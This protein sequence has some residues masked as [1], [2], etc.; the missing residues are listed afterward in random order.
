MKTIRTK[1]LVMFMA[2]A[3]VFAMTPQIAQT[4]VADDG[5]F[6]VP[7]T[8]TSGFNIDGV[9]VPGGGNVNQ[10]DS[11]SYCYYADADRAGSLPPG[12]VIETTGGKIFKLAPYNGKNVVRLNNATGNVSVNFSDDSKVECKK[13]AFLATGGNGGGTVT[14][15]V[16]FSGQNSIVSQNFTVPDWDDTE[17][18]V[19]TCGRC[20]TWGSN[21]TEK[22]D[23]GLFECAINIPAEYQGYKVDSL[24]LEATCSSNDA[25]ICIFAVS[26]V[27]TSSKLTVLFDGNGG[28]ATQ[29]KMTADANASITLPDATWEGVHF[30]GWFDGDTKVGDAG[31]TYTVTKNVLLKAHWTDNREYI[32]Y[33][34]TSYSANKVK[35]YKNEDGTWTHPTRSNYVFKGFSTAY[36][37]AVI[38]DSQLESGG[39][40]YAIWEEAPYIYVQWPNDRSP[41]RYYL[42]ESGKVNLPKK[43][44]TVENYRVDGYYKDSSLKEEIDVT[45]AI[46]KALYGKTIFAGT[47]RTGTYIWVQGKRITSKNCSDVLG[48]GKV[49]FDMKTGVL[50]LNNV[51]I[52]SVVTE[53]YSEGIT[54]GESLKIKLIGKNTINCTSGDNIYNYQA[55]IFA[56]GKIKISGSGSLTINMAADVDTEKYGLKAYGT[57]DIR[58]DLNIN[59]KGDYDSAGYGLFAYDDVT[60]DGS[61]AKISV[62]NSS[63]SSAYG[64]FCYGEDLYVKND[65]DLK[66]DAKTGLYAIDDLLIHMGS[67]MEVTG[68]ERAFNSVYL[69][70]EARNQ[71]VGYKEIGDTEYKRWESSS[72]Y[73]LDYEDIKSV[74]IPMNKTNHIKAVPRTCTK[75]GNIEYWSMVADGETVYYNMAYPDSDY[76]ISLA[77]TVVK[78]LGGEHKWVLSKVIKKATAKAAGK[79]LNK[80]TRC[81]TTKT[82]AIPKLALS[83]KGKTAKVS[84][85]TLEKKAVTVKKAKALT[86]KKSKGKLTYKKTG[87]IKKKFAGKF[88][89]N[90]KN[91]SIR[92]SKGLKKGTYK[93]K[94]KVTDAG[95]KFYAKR[96]KTVTVTIKVQ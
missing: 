75:N 83:V 52:K 63:D 50:T 23:F 10:L 17:G 57:V 45:K 33:Y 47:T 58:A 81:G 39:T 66:V 71:G 3:L 44:T 14:A 27:S 80:C 95:N 53:G 70:T 40:Y 72:G 74:L 64:I 1:L 92:V 9:Y 68:S 42:D 89:V 96:T 90:K 62:K 22:N 65:T 43:G 19:Y 54:S 59:I 77:D 76:E 32:W 86:V 48:N 84:A 36:N 60:F 38:D 5:G 35:L 2:I 73:G 11:S 8:V 85:K 20:T 82:V 18:A 51:T 30:D 87:V 41:N 37:G 28:T 26:G 61:N 56:D 15:K 67:K 21:F 24:D 25:T 46:P 4:A 55:G 16:H 34:L 6:Y 69:P 94:I 88:T 78:K 79:K 29:E 31:E 93:V 13:I 12:G 49:K 7:M 91:G